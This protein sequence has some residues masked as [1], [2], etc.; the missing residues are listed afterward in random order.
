[1]KFCKVTQQN[2]LIMVTQRN[3]I[4]DIFPS[5]FVQ[6]YIITTTSTSYL[7]TKNYLWTF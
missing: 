6:L 3:N 7:C 5:P 2:P 4:T 1:M